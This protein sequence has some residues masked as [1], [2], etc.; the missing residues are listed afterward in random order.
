MKDEIDFVTITRTWKFS[1]NH[2]FSSKN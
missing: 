1:K 2:N